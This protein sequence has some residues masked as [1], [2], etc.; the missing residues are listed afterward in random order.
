MFPTD[1]QT[2][3]QARK[4]AM[5]TGLR[6]EALIA[7]IDQ[8]LRLSHPGEPAGAPAALLGRLIHSGMAVVNLSTS[9]GDTIT[10]DGV[11]SLPGSTD[12]AY[13]LLANWQRAAR[14]SLKAPAETAAAQGDAA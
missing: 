3:L 5:I 2:A 6:T 8:H 9:T 7:L 11:T 12:S 4:D 14:R 10:L 1:M 13:A